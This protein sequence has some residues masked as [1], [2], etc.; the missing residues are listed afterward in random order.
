MTFVKRGAGLFVGAVVTMTALYAPADLSAAEFYDGK[1]IRVIIVTDA[2]GSYDLVG[3][4]IGRHIGKHIPGNPTVMPQNMP[5]A[6]GMAATNHIYNVAPQD[7]TVLGA[8]HP[9]SASLAPVLGN[10]NARFNPSKFNWIG[11]LADPSNVLAV[12]DTSPVKTWQDAK[13]T[14]A[15]IG[16]VS[17]DGADAMS[18]NL[19]NAVLG[20]KFKVVTGYPGGGP[21]MIAMERGEVNGRGIQTWAGWKATRPD[22]V[23]QKKIIPLYQVAIESDPE[24]K[25]VPLL[26]DL[27]EGEENKGAVRLFTNVMSLGRP[28]LAGPGV[29][30]ENV[31]ILRR[32]FEAT[33]KDPEFVAEAQKLRL[34]LSPMNGEQV[35]KIVDE[36]TSV[37]PAAIERFKEAVKWRN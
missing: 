4:L 1:T 5:G 33:M 28:M 26:V 10:P 29:P 8:V 32:A 15:T 18:A 11:T 12:L 6:S 3:R 21:I 7:G 13:R 24:L 34:E 22:W 14:E 23:E 19:A 31:R 27:A 17:A 35:Q 20:T 25:Q 16:A 37:S 36:M 30:V 9:V 2:G